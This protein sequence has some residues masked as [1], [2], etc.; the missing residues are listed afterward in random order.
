MSYFCIKCNQVHTL[1]GSGAMLFSTGFH[2]VDGKRLA[3]GICAS[4]P[5][6]TPHNDTQ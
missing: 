4:I 3:A 2:Y 1:L 5:Q 6:V